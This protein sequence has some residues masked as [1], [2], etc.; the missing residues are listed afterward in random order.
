[1]YIVQL[2]INC[3]LYY[4]GRR[5]KLHNFTL[6]EYNCTKTIVSTVQDAGA[7]YMYTKSV[8]LYKNYSVYCSGHRS[9]LRTC[10]LYSCTKNYSLYF[11]GR[12]S[13]LHNCTLYSCK[14]NYNLYCSGRRSKLHNCTFYS[15][16]YVRLVGLH[17]QFVYVYLIDSRL[18]LYL[19]HVSQGRAKDL[20]YRGIIV[21]LYYS[22]Q[23]INPG[24]SIYLSSISR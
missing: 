2:Y 18:S 3:S 8:Q 1:M 14:K 9:K 23:K 15:C 5:S 4:L 16:T 20:F 6:Y 24:L 12:R 7:S 22:G 17:L 11:S 13:K 19:S 21:P 10:T